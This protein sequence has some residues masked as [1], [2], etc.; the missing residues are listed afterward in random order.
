MSIDQKVADVV[1]LQRTLDKAEKALSEA[2]AELLALL[3]EAGQDKVET[4][5]AKVA[6]V[7]PT[8]RTADLDRL[9]EALK[10]K[11]FAEVTKVSVDWAQFD[12]LAPAVAA[13]AVTVAPGTPYVKVTVR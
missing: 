5:K 9:R 3:V 13:E 7:R 11:Q 4:P 10:P 12:R 6:V 1:R 8:K 2:K